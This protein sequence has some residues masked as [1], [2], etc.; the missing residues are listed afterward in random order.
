MKFQ[1]ERSRQFVTKTFRMPKELI[2]EL[3]GIANKNQISLNKLMI[4]IA[5]FALENMEDE[6][7]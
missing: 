3:E 2:D 7:E 6:K 1:V 4:Q 5:V